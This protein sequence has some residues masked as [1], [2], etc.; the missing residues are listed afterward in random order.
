MNAAQLFVK[1]L[2][3]EGVEVI[4]AVPGEE[5]LEVKTSYRTIRLL[6][7]PGLKNFLASNNPE[8]V[9]P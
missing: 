8:E 1:A 7:Q 4:Y 5:N 2:E 6:D 3:N 9:N